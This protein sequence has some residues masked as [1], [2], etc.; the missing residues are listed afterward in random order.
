[1]YCFEERRL[2]EEIIKRGVKR[3]FLQLPD[4]LK[5]NGFRL[6]HLIEE[7]TNAMVI[8]SADPC[9]GACDVGLVE[10]E[11]VNADLIIHY[12]HTQFLQTTKIP[13][14]YLEARVNLD[15]AT[16]IKKALSLLSDSKRIGLS[17]TV[18]H[19]HDIEKVKTMLE[20]E[21]K[22][23]V[24]GRAGGHVKYDG[25]VLG[26]DFTTAITISSCVDA[27]LFIGGGN[28][29]A[30]GI[31]LATGKRVI[32]ADPYLNEARDIEELRRY[33]YRQRWA[34]ITKAKEANNFGI[35]VS[36][37]PGQKKIDLAE[38]IKTE[39]KKN[40]KKAIII[41]MPEITPEGLT[42]FTDIDCFIDTACPRVAID[43]SSKFKRILLIPA[44]VSILLGKR[45][46]ED[47]AKEDNDV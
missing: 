24:V 38:R 3:V 1:M 33:V 10:A 23:V 11:Q 26:C 47:Y 32:V 36:S 25:Q 44:E 16:S 43:D 34:A 41:Y 39:L 28:F 31:A 22:R 6:A 35:I 37:K 4:G 15:T 19:I 40:G 9:Y 2:V 45:T 14:I 20:K 29:H 5:S 30:L 13:I 8:L 21:E 17:T 7:K 42:P 46:W 18:Q 27:F 12:G